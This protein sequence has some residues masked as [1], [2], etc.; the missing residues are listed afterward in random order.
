MPLDGPTHCSEGLHSSPSATEFASHRCAA[1][2]GQCSGC[3]RR[4][5]DLSRFA[6]LRSAFFGAFLGGE[7]SDQ[8]FEAAVCLLPYSVDPRD[9]SGCGSCTLELG[10]VMRMDHVDRTVCLTAI[11]GIGPG[12]ADMIGIFIVGTQTSGPMVIPGSL[13]LCL[14]VGR[15]SRTVRVAF[16]VSPWRSRLAMAMWRAVDQGSALKG[17]QWGS[18]F[19]VIRRGGSRRVFISH[20]VYG[21]HPIFRRVHWI[22]GDVL[23][24]LV[25][26]M[27]MKNFSSLLFALFLSLAAHADV[28]SNNTV[29]E[30]TQS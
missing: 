29:I 15:R 7:V 17:A 3:G 12:P 1:V 28:L 22:C 30:I 10:R 5:D 8:I 2:V 24:I 14:L 4:H 26:T 11:P 23:N 25:V 19:W 21:R 27:C 20:V 9:R 18:F 13:N 6:I 16:D